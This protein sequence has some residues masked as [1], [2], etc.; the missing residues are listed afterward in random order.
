MP[1]VVHGRHLA[2]DFP[3]SCLLV[4]PATEEDL[5]VGET[6]LAVGIVWDWRHG[7]MSWSVVQ[8]GVCFGHDWCVLDLDE[9]QVQTSIDSS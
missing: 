3:N 1:G 4:H 2:H 6:V 7:V 8:E 9:K 5:Y